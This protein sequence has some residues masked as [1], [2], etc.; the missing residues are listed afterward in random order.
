[1]A[2]RSGT[3]LTL[4]GV[5]LIAAVTL[6]VPQVRDALGDAL[7]GDTAAMRTELRDLGTGGVLVL[8]AIVLAHAIVFYPAEI[9]DAAAGYVWGFWLGLLLVHVGWVLSG[10]VAYAIGRYLGRPVVRRVVGDRRLAW[11]EA[12]IER[13][14]WSALV[15]ARLIPIVPF[16]LFS[17]VAGA[18]RVPPWRFGWTTAAGYLPLTA[19]S[20]LVGSRLHEFS[21]ADPLVWLASAG[22]IALAA[23]SWVVARAHRRDPEPSPE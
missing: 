22:L 11:A 5:C 4:L 19:L 20:V 13:G 10:F 1:M 3:V 23:L 9:V 16:S 8:E 18:A 14:G 7:S 6:G 17:Y 12:A 21:V 2:V 15:A